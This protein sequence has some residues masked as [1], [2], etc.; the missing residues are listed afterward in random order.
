VKRV[1][2]KLDE[3]QFCRVEQPPDSPDLAPC[4]LFL[5]GYLAD[6]TLFLSYGIVD[7]L[8]EAI[9]STIETIRKQNSFKLSRRADGD[10]RDA[11]SKKDTTLRKQNQMLL[12]VFPF[13]HGMWVSPDA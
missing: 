8:Q 2:Q 4:D 9:P 10:Q 5:F 12:I 6:T 11:S 7:E 3:C 13:H 1:K